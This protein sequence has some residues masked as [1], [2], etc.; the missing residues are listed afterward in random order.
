VTTTALESTNPPPA[1]E[2][3]SDAGALAEVTATGWKLTLREF[4]KNK[5]AMTGL[6]ILVL[7]VLFCYLGPVF[8]HSNQVTENLLNTDN[9]PGA[10]NPLGTDDSGFDV[11]GRLMVGGQTSLEIGFAAAAIATVVGTLVGAVSGLVGGWLDAVLMRFV[12]ILLALPYLLIVLIFV[13]K[14]QA[15]V[16]SLIM[17]IGLF[18]WLVPAR[19][20]RGEVLTLR[21]RD[22]VS[23][24][25]VMGAGNQRLIYRHLIPNAMGTVIVN[26]TFLIADAILALAALSF[27]G[28]GLKYPNT[29]W[30]SQ[31]ANSGEYLTDDYWWLVLPVGV[32]LVLVVM[33]FNLIGDGLRDAFDVRLRKR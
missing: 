2:G 22:F 31:I 25:K 3:T 11:L 29:D 27:L 10:G 24:A 16:A 21:V 12:D 26:I 17:I 23:A 5:L 20:V 30:G 13:N 28:F 33:A 4:T 18:A 9:P 8:Y 6:G 1:P 32:S 14:F 19:L 15:S 7:F